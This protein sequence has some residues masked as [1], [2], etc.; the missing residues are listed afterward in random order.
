MKAILL[1]LLF[2]FS[3]SSFSQNY[4]LI[5]KDDEASCTNYEIVDSL[6]AEI[7]LPKM[8]ASALL[9]PSVL[10]LHGNRLVYREHNEIMMYNLDKQSFSTL[11]SVYDD[12]DGIS[13]PHWS[14]DGNQLLFVIVNQSRNHG[15]SEFC[16]IIYLELNEEGTV[17][18]KRKF[19]RPVQFV[20]GSIC[21][22]EPGV[23]FM[24][25]NEH[26]IR[27]KV[28]DAIEFDGEAIQEIDLM[29]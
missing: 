12:I 15:Y 19:D 11:F 16:R 3:L 1:F 8:V 2:G 18:D 25:S 5:E 23:D 9:C 13:S 7:K 17:Q 21:S 29:K 26:I 4:T 6:D 24:F 28:H 14:E 22:S 27:Y 20:C 10:S